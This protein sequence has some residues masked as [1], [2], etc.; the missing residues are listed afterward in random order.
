V[1]SPSGESTDT[2]RLDP[3]LTIV[4]AGGLLFLDTAGIIY[5]RDFIRTQTERENSPPMGLVRMRANGTVIDTVPPPDLPVLAFPSLMARGTHGSRSAQVPY[6]PTTAWAWSPFGHA[7]TGR[8]DRYAIDLRIP[9]SSP[10]GGGT[11]A[12]A[13]TLWKAGDPVISIRRD[14]RPVPIGDAERSARRTGMEAFLRAADPQWSW[15]GPDIPRFKPAFRA[16]R[17][18]QDGRIWVTTAAP[19]EPYTPEPTSNPAGRVD[20]NVPFREPT[21]YDVFETDGTFLGQLRLP[22]R[23]TLAITKGDV[24]WAI[25]RDEDDVQTLQRFRIVWK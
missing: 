9:P 21:V 4:G 1:Y 12:A 17:V 11:A 7:V 3:G 6:A 2:W 14:V 5:R 10:G 18:A 16:I 23:T 13:S 25:V 24:A 20:S 8:T 19:S 22:V 15:N